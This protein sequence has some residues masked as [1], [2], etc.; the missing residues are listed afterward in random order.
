MV[1]NL[2]QVVLMHANTHLV[3]S[4]GTIHPEYKDKKAK[5]YFKA[6]TLMDFPSMTADDYFASFGLEKRLSV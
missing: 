1:L 5:E 3:C 4:D 6:L 2:R